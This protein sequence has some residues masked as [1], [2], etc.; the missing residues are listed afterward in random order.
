M[1]P[2]LVFNGVSFLIELVPTRRATWSSINVIAS[3]PRRRIC[4]FRLNR[5]RFTSSFFYIQRTQPGQSRLMNVIL[6][7]P[8]I[9]GERENWKRFF[10]T[11]RTINRGGNQDRVL[12]LARLTGAALFLF[13]FCCVL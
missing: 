10:A 11:E 6:L 3:F 4:S 2:C 7:L 9:S 8:R 12:T 1:V 5:R 13:F